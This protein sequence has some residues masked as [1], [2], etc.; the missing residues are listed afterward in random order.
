MPHSAPISRQH[1][2]FKLA[3]AV[4]VGRG[5]AYLGWTEQ[6]DAPLNALTLYFEDG[7]SHRFPLDTTDAILVRTP[8]PRDPTDHSERSAGGFAIWIPAKPA[9]GSQP[10]VTLNDQAADA[11]EVVALPPAAAIDHATLV[12]AYGSALAALARSQRDTALA[13]LLERPLAE[14]AAQRGNAFGAVE[15]AWHIAG[16]LL[17][18]ARVACEPGRIQTLHYQPGRGRAVDLTPQLQRF[19]LPTHQDAEGRVVPGHISGIAFVVPAASLP[20]GPGAFLRVSVAGLGELRLPLRPLEGT[21]DDLANILVARPHV[22]P[23]VLEALRKQLRAPAARRQLATLTRQC[24]EGLWP[25]TSNKHGYGDTYAAAITG[26]YALGEGGLAAF[27]ILLRP[28]QTPLRVFLHAEERA[29]IDITRHMVFLPIDG[30]LTP[31]QER[32]PATTRNLSFFVHAPLATAG[33]ERRLLRFVMPGIPDFWLKAETR[34]LQETG[35]TLVRAMLGHIPSSPW[36]WRNFAKVCDKGLGKV[37]EHAAATRSANRPVPQI[38]EF[39]KPPRKP[40]VSVIVP[41]YGRYDFMRHQLAQFCDDSD[42]ASGVDLI[43][44][45]D[46]PEIETAA[47]NL[48]ARYQPLF[49]VPLRVVTYG[50]NRGFAGANNAAAALARAPMLLLMNSDVLPQQAGWLSTLRNAFDKLP[51]CGM[52]APLLQYP[53]GSV[54][55]AGMEATRQMGNPGL[56]FSHHPGKGA[57]WD[58]GDAPAEKPMLT[59]ACLLLQTKDYASAGGLDEGYIVGDFEDSDFSLKLRALRKRLYLIPSA[60]LWHLER[61]SQYAGGNTHLIRDMLTLY[62]AWRYNNK[63]AAG[64][65][66][67]PEKLSVA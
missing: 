51:R 37:L 42:F 40:W 28:E 53:E 48:A 22:V 10:L 12:E 66:P 35:T 52:V 2:S 64:S 38:H 24:F 59:G 9:K 14:L 13:K 8:K 57:A 50:E 7:T 15:H 55:H 21:T 4:P 25:R 62:N 46:D 49:E 58:G 31:L 26:A 34:A 33:G 63:I 19:P 47:L 18:I 41:L 3:L 23:L 6:P 67:N 60:R 39:G 36:L 56:I 44:V 1:L 61:Q 45:V 29:P 20:S 65:I 5:Q 11:S 27:G 16:Q 43:Y 54:Q 17:V 30:D 32:I